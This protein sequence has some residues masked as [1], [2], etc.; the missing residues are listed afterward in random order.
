[1]R[2]CTRMAVLKG[3][4]GEGTL[5]APPVSRGLIAVLAV[6]SLGVGQARAD[7]SGG[8]PVVEQPGPLPRRDA[9]A[10]AATGA[11]LS[12]AQP[13]ALRDTQ[14]V[15]LAIGG[16]DASRSG[17]SY[18]AAAEVRVFGPLLLRGG[19]VRTA[20]A[21]RLR[22]SFGARVEALGEQRHGLD[23]SV[24]VFY[25][26]EGLTEPE[27]E[28]ET[29]VA[30]GR[31]VGMTYLLANLLYGQDPEGSE[32]DGEFRLAA[33]RHLGAG[34]RWLLGFDGRARFDLGSNSAKL[35]QNHEATVDAMA[36]PMVGVTLGPVALA[37]QGGG[38]SR[39]LAGDTSYGAFGMLTLG[40]TWPGAS[41]GVW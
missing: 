27:G 9:R 17:A 20:S 37:L 26:P 39:R 22:P 15:V 3:R 31:H 40:C 4:G 21:D 14:A 2:V 41:S 16:Y 12:F 25:R 8:E 34:S 10:V 35:A 1:M 29:V 6:T 24:G 13:A 33:L 11:F 36:G 5:W 30:V 7:Q 32:R 18:E 23:G 28:I 19:V 38:A